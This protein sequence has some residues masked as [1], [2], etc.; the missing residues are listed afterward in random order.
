MSEPWLWATGLAA[1]WLN[2]SL[3]SEKHR[4]P[5]SHKALYQVLSLTPH[6]FLFVSFPCHL[7]PCLQG[8][9][10]WL[11]RGRGGSTKVAQLSAPQEGS[12]LVPRPDSSLTCSAPSPSFP[13]PSATWREMIWGIAADAIVTWDRITSKV[14]NSD[15]LLSQLSLSFFQ[16]SHSFTPRK[17]PPSLQNMLLEIVQPSVSP[18]VCQFHPEL[19]PP[20]QTGAQV[21]YMNCCLTST[22]GSA[23]SHS[24]PTYR[25]KPPL[26]IPP[27]ICFL[28]LVTHS[29]R[30]SHH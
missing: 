20:P 7:H 1:A 23:A 4:W 22:F 14:L 19:T 5:W 13:F 11:R 18:S 2:Q 27:A 26:R 3:A 8:A 17:P 6:S 29:W 24:R 25:A 30:K 28:L 9:A 10:I 12:P 15:I 16:F 21:K